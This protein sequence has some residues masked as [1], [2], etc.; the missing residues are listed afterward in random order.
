VKKFLVNGVL[1][2]NRRY[3][4]LFSDISFGNK[5]ELIIHYTDT[6]NQLQIVEFLENRPVKIV[7]IKNINKASYRVKSGLK[8]LVNV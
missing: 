4:H 3:N 2:I 5:K 6:K 1:S 7:D 8:C